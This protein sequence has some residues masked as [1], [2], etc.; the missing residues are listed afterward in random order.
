[1]VTKRLGLYSQGGLGRRSK[2]V[3]WKARG[4]LRRPKS[5]Q[6][7]SQLRIL[8]GVVLYQNAILKIEVSTFC[9]NRRNLAEDDT[10][11]ALV[12]PFRKV[13]GS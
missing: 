11:M 6:L 7:F 4:F 8:V 9:E 12:R 3:F 1:M 10:Y 2:C 5:F 13:L